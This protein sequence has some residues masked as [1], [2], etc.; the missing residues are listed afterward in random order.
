MTLCVEAD[1]FDPLDPNSMAKKC[2][3]E[4]KLSDPKAKEG[5]IP[6]L[7]AV[8]WDPWVGTPPPCI[9]DRQWEVR[10]IRPNMV[11]G[12]GSVLNTR[13]CLCSK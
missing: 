10:H 4:C 6:I 11:L 8:P 9:P 12:A 2:D 1:L 7:E 5:S 13:A 3:L